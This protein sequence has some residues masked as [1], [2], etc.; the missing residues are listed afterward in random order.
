MALE[1]ESP[2]AAA[3]ATG[4]GFAENV[5]NIRAT[6]SYSRTS[7]SR[8]RKGMVRYRCADGSIIALSGKR[9][10]VLARLATGVGVS[11]LDCFPWHTRLGASIHDMRRAGLDIETRIEPSADGAR[12]AR[13]FLRTPGRLLQR[14]SG[15][16]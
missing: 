1:K 3:T 5:E 6:A 10:R 11:Q 8:N 12:H 16:V 14:K 15:A 2:R 9:G 7:N 4:T 13:Y